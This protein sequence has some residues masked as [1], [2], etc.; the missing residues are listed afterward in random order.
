MRADK[1]VSAFARELTPVA[2][3][4]IACSTD[5]YRGCNATELAAQLVSAVDAPVT[6][7]DSVIEAIE[8]A[9]RRT[10]PGGRILVCGS[11]MLVGSVLESLGLY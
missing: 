10:E 2:N 1:D 4:W 3:R 5:G 11:F 9:R 6:T 8:V 7:A